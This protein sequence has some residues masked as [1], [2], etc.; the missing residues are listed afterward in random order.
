MWCVC[1]LCAVCARVAS[2][3]VLFFSFYAYTR[4]SF[5]PKRPF[6]WL[7]TEIQ[8]SLHEVV[9]SAFLVY[10]LGRGADRDT[11]LA[12]LL[13]GDACHKSDIAFS[14][15]DVMLVYGHAARWL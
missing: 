13:R 15:E 2:R 10:A 8:Q 6:G 9:Q 11:F 7:V 5:N 3:L 4:T 14:V 12:D 1:V